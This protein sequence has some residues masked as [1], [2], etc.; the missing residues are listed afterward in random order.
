[1]AFRN[2]DSITSKSSSNGDSVTSKSSSN[3]D[4]IT[5]STSRISTEQETSASGTVL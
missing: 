5:S 3:G 4:S 1:M 2:G